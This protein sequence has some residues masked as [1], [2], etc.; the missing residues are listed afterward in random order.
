MA[1]QSLNPAGTEGEA[2]LVEPTLHWLVGAIVFSFGVVWLGFSYLLHAAHLK[3]GMLFAFLSALC[4]LWRNGVLVNYRTRTYRALRGFLPFVKTLSGLFT[5]FDHIRLARES[6]DD[7]DGTSMF[8]CVCLIWKENR[9]RTDDI[10]VT[11][12]ASRASA[13][14]HRLASALGLR[15]Y[16]RSAEPAPSEQKAWYRR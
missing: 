15:L 5:D 13:E 2:V 7:G 16:D 9:R 8:W 12:D 1:K 3:G 11:R 14:A 4:F 10:L 6:R